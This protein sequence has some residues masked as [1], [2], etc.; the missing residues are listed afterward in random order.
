VQA[1]ALGTNPTGGLR[2]VQDEFTINGKIIDQTTYFRNVLFADF[3]W[4]TIRQ[5]P[6]VEIAV[7]PFHVFID[8]K[9]IGKFALEVRHKPS[10]EAGQHNYT[11]SISWGDLGNVI[12]D[13]NL[14]GAQL[15]VYVSDSQGNTFAMVFTR[16]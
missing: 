9:H 2:L 14:T 10:G 12:R 7:V 16:P 5:E 3:K 1:S 6:V 11:T 4:K 13:A 15:D 8:E